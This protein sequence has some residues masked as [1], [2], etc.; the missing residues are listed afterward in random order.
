MTQDVTENRW[1]KNL[2]EIEFHMD[3]AVNKTIGLTSFQALMGYTPTLHDSLLTLLTV[4]I[5]VRSNLE[6]EFEYTCDWKAKHDTHTSK[7]KYEVGEIIM[8][9]QP[10]I[11]T[12]MSTKL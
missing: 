12:G 2:D 1:D 7:M 10:A 11:S 9:L 6:N 5:Q 8:L 4:T 3:S